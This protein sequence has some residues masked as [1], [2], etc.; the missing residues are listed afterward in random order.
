MQQRGRE[1]LVFIHT[2]IHEDKTWGKKGI[3]TF[4]YNGPDQA[5]NMEMRKV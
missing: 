3:M 1:I 5:K 4:F 2:Y